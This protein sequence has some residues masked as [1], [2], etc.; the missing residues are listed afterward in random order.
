MSEDENNI[1]TADIKEKNEVENVRFRKSLKYAVTGLSINQEIGSALVTVTDVDQKKIL[2]NA[3]QKILKEKKEPDL[4]LKIS[5]PEKKRYNNIVL[6]KSAATVHQKATKK[7]KKLSSTITFKT[8]KS[9]VFFG[10]ISILILG[11]L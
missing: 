3:I 7:M 6:K 10:K 2:S 8:Y 5:N 1:S 11:I 9:S 4:D